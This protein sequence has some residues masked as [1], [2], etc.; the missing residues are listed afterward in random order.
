MSA[1]STYAQIILIKGK[2]FDNENKQFLAGATIKVGTA[3]TKTNAVGN[4]ELAVP[5][6]DLM[7]KG[8]NFSYIGYLNKR[9][10]Y[11][12]KHFY[13]VEMIQ[14]T[15]QLNEVVITPGDD[16]MK[17]AIN[18]IPL[19]YPNQAIML[20]GI[21]RMQEWRNKSQ[22]FKTDAIIKAYIPPYGSSKNT[23]V[24]VIHN[25][26]DTL[27]DKTIEYIRFLN[28]YNVVGY[29]D[30]VHNKDLLN[31][32]SKKRKYDY[33]LLGKEMYNN[34]RVYV[35]NTALTDSSKVLDKFEATFY[36]D[37]ASY[38]FVAANYSY[39]KLESAK[40]NVQ[41]TNKETTRR[42]SY[43]KK[44]GS[45]WYLAEVNQK[46]YRSEFKNIPLQTTVNFIRTEIDSINVAPIPYNDIIQKDDDVLKIN[47]PNDLEEWEKYKALF[48]KAELEGTIASI[49]QSLLDTIRLNNAIANPLG[50]K[51]KKS[52]VL[53]AYDYLKKDN[54]RSTLGLTQLPTELKSDLF[55]IPESVNYGFSYDMNYRFY[56]N[57]FLGLEITNNFWNKKRINLSTIGLNLSNEFVINKNARNI[58]FT[59]FVGY[60]FTTIKYQKAKENYTSFNYGMRA[61]ID[62]TRKK[63]LFVSSGFN[64]AKGVSNLSDLR[65]MPTGYALSFGILFK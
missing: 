16:I 55:N 40:A 25:Q 58:I 6:I 2:V 51:D 56:K 26:L 65:I 49:S 62:L 54:V 64:T 36:I 12:P 32:I 61:A 23:T 17:K 9:L 35:I 10:I 29:G 38:A 37:T 42:V 27:H 43:E 20:N 3:A 21:F 63:A 41:K 5:L 59:P 14:N 44:I 33:R 53:R 11:Q 60:Q 18:N 57:F 24:M 46:Y 45:K 52:F 13:Q 15:N 47:K 19:N 1:T 4:F 34:H 48:K 50:Q 30:I 31:Q 28:F 39:Y 7:E 22:Y 8:I